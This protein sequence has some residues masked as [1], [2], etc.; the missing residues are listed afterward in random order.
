MMTLTERII[1][2]AIC[3]FAT[4]ST[5]FLP[6]LVFSEKRS[7]PKYIT[8]LGKALPAAIFAMLIVYCLRNVNLFSG[9]NGIPEA[10]AI[11]VTCALY[12]WKRQIL[13]PIAGGTISYML[14]V[15]FVF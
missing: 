4:M 2:I 1:T 13:I 5:R 10:L 15:Q 7:T 3:A 12:F 14:L 8:Y 6:F 11:I 9:S